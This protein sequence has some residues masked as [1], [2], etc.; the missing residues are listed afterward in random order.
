MADRSR[1]MFEEAGSASL[2]FPGICS[3]SVGH[4]PSQSKLI[5]QAVSRSKL[6][7]QSDNQSFSQTA[8]LTVV[9]LFQKV[10]EDVKVSINL[11]HL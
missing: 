6:A 11:N 3:P 10:T 1:L 9:L 7:G 8:N 2:S 5:S 4:S